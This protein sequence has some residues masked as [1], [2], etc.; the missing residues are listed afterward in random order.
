MPQRFASP[1]SS[2]A[3][4]KKLKVPR[5]CP[6]VETHFTSVF[7]SL[8][9]YLSSSSTSGSKKPSNSAPTSSASERSSSPRTV[10][11]SPA[12]I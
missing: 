5:E 11:A 1:V 8:S 3:S 9:T 6:G 10:S 7:S 2:T 12:P 4:K